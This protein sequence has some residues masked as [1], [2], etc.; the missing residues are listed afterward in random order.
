M[1]VEYFG[2]V[3]GSM[4]LAVVAQPARFLIWIL[5][6][7]ALGIACTWGCWRSGRLVHL[8]HRPGVGALL[9]A[10]V[11]G[12]SA[13]WAVVSWSSVSYT[14]T[15]V[16]EV[17]DLG[18][19]G[20][21]FLTLRAAAACRAAQLTIPYLPRAVPQNLRVDCD[22]PQAAAHLRAALGAAA[23]TVHVQ[24]QNRLRWN[25]VLTVAGSVLVLVLAAG[26]IGWRA[27][28]NFVVYSGSPVRR[29]QS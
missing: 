5:L 22:S 1:L 6:A 16:T 2:V 13:F 9:L 21:R 29:Y 24:L 25:Q 12:V 3:V 20:T 28:R 17:F 10:L 27:S 11:A 23:T 7:A 15:A 14:R 8:G 26:M 19:S 4:A 18:D